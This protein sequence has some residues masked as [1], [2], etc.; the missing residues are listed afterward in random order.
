MKTPFII[1]LFSVLTMSISARTGL[2]SVI[3]NSK[4]LFIQT[5]EWKSEN[6]RIQIIEQRGEVILDETVKTSTGIRKYNLKNLPVGDYTLEVSDDLKISTRKFE[7]LSKNVILSGDNEIFYKPIVFWN[8]KIM[9]LNLLN[10]GHSAEV[11]I[12][13]E[14][15]NVVLTQDF[16]TP[17]VH[18]RYDISLLPRGPYNVNVSSN[19]RSYQFYYLK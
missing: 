10:L 8:S 15:N 14:N 5:S 4:S 6:I 19:G 17:V 2:E 18:K 16:K 11:T 3:E 12:I 1:L 9:D 7:I 13:D